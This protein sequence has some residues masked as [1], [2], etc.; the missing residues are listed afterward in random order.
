M[1]L[2]RSLQ[3]K[4][5]ESLKD[6]YPN[7]TNVAPIKASNEHGWFM[8]N[9]HY[10][11]EH[12]LI[13]NIIDSG[14]STKGYAPNIIQAKITAK[15]LDFLEDDGGVSA[16]LKTITV[17]FDPEDL[18]KLL[19]IKLDKT[20]I[21]PEEKESLMYEIKKLPAKALKTFYTK[22]INLGLDSAQDAYHLIKTCLE[23]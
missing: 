8:P 22:L 19:S 9:M 7:I 15:G 13:I 12:G 16:I 17:K 2:D 21:P 3:L 1:K 5:L 4:I 10:L 11:I 18:H 14:F 20:N 23:D 6:N